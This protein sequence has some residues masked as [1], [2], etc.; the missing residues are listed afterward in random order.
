[1]KDQE[2][3]I[4]RVMFL[5]SGR[6]KKPV[7]PVVEKGRYKNITCNQKPGGALRHPRKRSRAHQTPP[8]KKKKTPSTAI[9]DYYDQLYWLMQVSDQTPNKAIFPIFQSTKREI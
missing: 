1:M 2:Y 8:Q 4:Y 6:L 3:S 7:I 5:I 9:Y